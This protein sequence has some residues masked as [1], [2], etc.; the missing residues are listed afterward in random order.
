MQTPIGPVGLDTRGAD[1]FDAIGRYVGGADEVY[2]FFAQLYDV[3]RGRHGDAPKTGVAQA[4]A[5]DSCV[6]VG[7][8][9]RA[10][11]G[12]ARGRGR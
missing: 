10:F 5:W 9:R 6:K 4:I 12:L 8:G 7:G 2:L 3:D 1:F 11:R